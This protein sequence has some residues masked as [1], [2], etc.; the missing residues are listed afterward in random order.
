MNL[1]HHAQHKY[2][3][4]SISTNVW[5]YLHIRLINMQALQQPFLHINIKFH[6]YARKFM[7]IYMVKDIWVH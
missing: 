5:N 2:F 4:F 3:Q 6:N 1:H 7:P